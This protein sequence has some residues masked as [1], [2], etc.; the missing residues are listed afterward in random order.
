MGVR[1]RSGREGARR[2]CGGAAVRR[3]RRRGVRA[4]GVE[5]WTRERARSAESAPSVVGGLGPWAC[6]VRRRAGKCVCE[7][8]CDRVSGDAEG[9]MR[10]RG[11]RKEAVTVSR[12]EV[13]AKW[14]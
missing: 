7:R 13:V 12:L 10:R 4:K 14:G 11:G 1:A 9:G 8:R 5:R 3:R 2:G 6:A